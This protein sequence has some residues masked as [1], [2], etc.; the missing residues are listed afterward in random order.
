ML[1]ATLQVD[2]GEL[3]VIAHNGEQAPEG[4]GEIPSFKESGIDVGLSVWRALVL[5]KETPPEIAAGWEKIL[6]DTMR[7]PALRDAYK[8]VSIGYAYKN[9]A[10]TE[11]LVQESSSVLTDLSKKAGLIK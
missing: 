3:K 7:D 4:F 9:Q 2:S 10:E 5:P 6:A 8:A 11:V 1:C